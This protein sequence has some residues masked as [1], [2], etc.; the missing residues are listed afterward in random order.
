LAQPANQ[1]LDG[2]IIKETPTPPSDAAPKWVHELTDQN[3]L[4]VYD[5]ALD[6]REALQH[7]DDVVIPLLQYLVKFNVLM[8]VDTIPMRDRYC[9]LRWNA[10][11]LL[12]KHG[13]ISDYELLRDFHR[14]QSR[15]RIALD[16]ALFLSFVEVIDTEYKQ[17]TRSRGPT[18]TS[19]GVAGSVPIRAA[20]RLASADSPVPR[21]GNPIAGEAWWPLDARHQR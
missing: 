19:Q 6:I 15:L 4:A 20:R 11:G 1:A 2:I 16:S 14:W 9:E 3:F 5:A 17:R 8:P 10:V 13:V 7:S 21:C 18:D 12:K